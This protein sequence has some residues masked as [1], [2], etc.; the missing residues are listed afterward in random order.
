MAVSNFKELKEHIGHDVE[1]ASYVVGNGIANVAIECNEC[2]MVLLDFDNPKWI[3]LQTDS[4][5]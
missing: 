3:D 1:V 5:L 4:K 2:G